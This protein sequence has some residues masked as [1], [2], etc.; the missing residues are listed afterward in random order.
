MAMPSAAV[1]EARLFTLGKLQQRQRGA[2]AA[3]AA[4]PI[5][6]TVSIELESRDIYAVNGRMHTQ[7]QEPPTKGEDASHEQEVEERLLLLL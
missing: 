6:A 5:A 1:G 4:R 3:A 2:A 7:E